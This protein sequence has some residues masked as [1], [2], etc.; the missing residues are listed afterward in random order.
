MSLS[1]CECQKSLNCAAPRSRALQVLATTKLRLWRMAASSIASKEENA[2]HQTWIA[3]A[4]AERVL[5]SR[6]QDA[7]V[8]LWQPSADVALMA[9]VAAEGTRCSPAPFSLTLSIV[10]EYRYVWELAHQ[11]NTKQKRWQYGSL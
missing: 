8:A 10:V 6:A 1:F 4:I 2:L 7:L 11:N 5:S 9:P 3:L